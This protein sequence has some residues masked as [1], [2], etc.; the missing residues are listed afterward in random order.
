MPEFWHPTGRSASVN[1]AA[2][3]TCPHRASTR[4]L[5]ARSRPINSS[6]TRCVYPSPQHA[7]ATHPGP[8]CPAPRR[9]LRVDPRRLP[10]APARG[11]SRRTRACRHHRH[12]C[13]RRC[14]CTRTRGRRPCVGRAWSRVRHPLR[15]GDRGGHRS[16]HRLRTTTSTP[17]TCSTVA[18]RRSNPNEDRSPVDPD[19]PGAPAAL[20]RRIAGPENSGR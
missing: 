9:V 2:V 16:E 15:P 13:N 14:T 12:P 5:R 3:T 11:R 20:P 10:S 1:D 7:T 8:P 19:R 17:A 4:P 6:L 18:N